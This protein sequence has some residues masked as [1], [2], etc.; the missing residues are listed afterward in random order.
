VWGSLVH[1]VILSILQLAAVRHS[2]RPLLARPELVDLLGFGLGSAVSNSVNY[3]ALNADNF[4]VGRSMGAA[5]LGLY[6]RAYGLMNLPFTYVAGVV[7][8]VMFPAFAQVQREPARL[9]RGYLVLT[10][11][12]AMVAAPSMVTMAVVAPHFVLSLYGSRWIG[13]V[14]P[15]QILCLAGYFR[16]LYHLGGIVAQSVGQIYGELWRQIIYAGLVIGG[17]L[18][19]SRFGLAG[20]AAG[21]GVAILYM[22]IATGHLAL[23]STGTPWRLYLRVQAGAL[24]TA[25]ATCIAALSIRVLFEASRASSAT[26]TLA[27]L[28][29]AAVPWS[30]GM[31][32]TLSD[33]D[34]EPLVACL[35]RWGARLVERLGSRGRVSRQR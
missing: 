26:I 17:A 24:V 11:L 1:T 19:G 8:G 9:R 6:G 32:W 10:E 30:V 22:F 4:V 28:A 15:L 5:S 31:L 20:V 2:V 16:A 25:G 35:P 3:V 13:V 34:F 18:I 27:I 33:P 12:T 7:S 21:V 29:A 23:R 14:V